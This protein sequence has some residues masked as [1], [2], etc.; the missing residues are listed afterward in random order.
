MLFTPSSSSPNHT[1]QHRLQKKKKKEEEEEM[2]KVYLWPLEHDD[3]FFR[4]L[5][6]L[7]EGM[8]QSNR[9]ME[10]VEADKADLVFY[11]L[12]G[13]LVNTTTA[14]GRVPADKLV[15]LDFGDHS[16]LMV[17]EEYRWV[18]VVVEGWWR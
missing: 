9:V 3:G 11:L 15:V 7:Y 17:G 6:M 10:V 14:L 13:P 12:T 2:I 4:E 1:P 5:L 18:V 8:A 16:T